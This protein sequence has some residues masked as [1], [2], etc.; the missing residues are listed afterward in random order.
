MPFT[1]FASFY[2]KTVT[3]LVC[4]QA[5]GSTTENKHWWSLEWTDE[6]ENNNK[7]KKK[8]LLKDVLNEIWQ[9]TER[10]IRHLITFRTDLDIWQVHFEGINKH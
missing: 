10:Y 2:P 8:L 7:I 6:N 4:H 3:N 1:V 5:K 9:S